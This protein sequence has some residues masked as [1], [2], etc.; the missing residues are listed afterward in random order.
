MG[1]LLWHFDLAFD[2]NS[3]AK[4]ARKKWEDAD[5]LVW[6][7]WVKPPMLVKMKEVTR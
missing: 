6:H 2:E 1:S 7:V 4:A 3:V 5:M